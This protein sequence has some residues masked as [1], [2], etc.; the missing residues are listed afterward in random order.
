[1]KKRKKHYKIIAKAM[2]VGF[3]VVL[4]WRGAWGLMDLYLFPGNEHLSFVSSIALGSAI[5][6]GTHYFVKE[7]LG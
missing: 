1:M 5:L 4:F 3:G 7:L 6:A 2:L